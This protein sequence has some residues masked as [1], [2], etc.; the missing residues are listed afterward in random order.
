MIPGVL[1]ERK[2]NNT[3]LGMGAQRRDT[4]AQ[5]KNDGTIERDEGM[6]SGNAK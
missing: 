5:E 3:L 2:D 1:C 6:Q 4:R